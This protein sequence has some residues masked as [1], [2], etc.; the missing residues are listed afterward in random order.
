[1][2]EPGEHHIRMRERNPN[3]YG[4]QDD[5]KRVQAIEAQF[6]MTYTVTVAMTPF[7]F[8]TYMDVGKSKQVTQAASVVAINPDQVADV[9]MSTNEVGEITIALVGHGIRPVLEAPAK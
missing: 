2:E 6:I 3:I 9:V 1:M 5:G 4:I 8:R 7:S